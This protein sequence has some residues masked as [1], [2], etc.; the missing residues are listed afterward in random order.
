MRLFTRLVD[1]YA[2]L[3]W[4]SGSPSKRLAIPRNRFIQRLLLYLKVTG[5]TAASVTPGEDNILALL[6]GI[7]VVRGGD[8]VVSIAGKDLAYSNCFDKGRFPTCYLITTVSQT[9]VTIGE[10]DLSIDFM[11]DPQND[12]DFHGLLPAHMLPS[13]DLFIDWGDS[14]DLGTGYT[15]TAAVMKVTLKEVSLDA[16]DLAQVGSLWAVKLSATEKVIDAAYNN[17]LFPLDLPTGKLIQKAF[18]FAY[19]N[20]VRSDSIIADP[21]FKLY[22]ADTEFVRL[23]WLDSQ[24]AL[25]TWAYIPTNPGSFPAAGIPVPGRITGFTSLGIER[26]SPLGLDATRY[27]AGDLRAGFVTGT[28]TATAKIRLLTKELS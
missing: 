20:S 16:R 25:C 6:K 13:L 8:T 10:A 19:N 22:D 4:A 24:H 5:N 21:G 23:P 3:A 27:K 11:I 1:N 9:G 15:V 26:L 17:Y 2:D 18:I 12:G 7:R 28:P 14:S